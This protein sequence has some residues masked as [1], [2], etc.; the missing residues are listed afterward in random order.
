MISRNAAKRRPCDP[1]HSQKELKRR[2][3]WPKQ[4][5]LELELSVRWVVV[6]GTLLVHS[7][8][9]KNGT[10]QCK[11]RTAC[12]A[13]VAAFTRC[14]VTRLN[15]L[16]N[17]HCMSSHSTA[18]NC[19]GR[20]HRPSAAYLTHWL[21]SFSGPPGGSRVKRFPGAGPAVVIIGTVQLSRESSLCQSRSAR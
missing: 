1:V 10:A 5:C 9:H 7:G 3:Q 20:R 16:H 21:F 13:S 15:F 14:H 4:G 2:I 18:T 11:R 8:A 12:H 6:L 17:S 19:G